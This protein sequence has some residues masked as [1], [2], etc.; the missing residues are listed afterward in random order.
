MRVF[1]VDGTPDTLLNLDIARQNGIH[2]DRTKKIDLYHDAGCS[3]HVEGMARIKTN[4]QLIAIKNRLLVKFDTT[5]SDDLNRFTSSMICDP[6]SI[7]QH[8]D[9]IPVCVTTA[10]QVP[11]HFEPESNKTVQE[12]INR[13][14]TT[15]V[16]EP[17]TWCSPAFFVSKADGKRVQTDFIALNKYMQRPTHPFPSTRE[18][19]KQSRRM[20]NSSSKWT[21]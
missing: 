6:R 15:P 21:Q 13:H 2:I 10:R 14:V 11:K 12:L 8:D 19:L 17:T 4:E 18:L 3:M 1:W 5:Q 7:K 20:Q 16:H 9:A